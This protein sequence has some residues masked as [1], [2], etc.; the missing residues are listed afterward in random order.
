MNIAVILAGGTG[1]RMGTDKPKQFLDIE[2]RSVIERSIDA[3]EAA[4]LNPVMIENIAKGRVQKFL[5]E[6]T[7]EEQEYQMCDD[8]KTVK[9]AIAAED[10]DAKVLFTK[11]F[12]LTD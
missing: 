7:L 9:E 10:K 2:G 1:S 3:F 6:N 8:K 5:K 12:S 4:N 11:R